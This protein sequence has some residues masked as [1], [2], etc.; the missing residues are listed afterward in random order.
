M[1]KKII[2]SFIDTV[3]ET[4]DKMQFID[5]DKIVGD[6]L[7]KNKIVGIWIDT[8]ERLPKNVEDVFIKGIHEDG[9]L[10][11]HLSWRCPD[12]KQRYFD[13]HSKATWSVGSAKNYTVTHWCYINDP[14]D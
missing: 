6:L 12:V 13:K 5:A 3:N 11:Y 7:D 9:T 8:K 1:D 2:Q 10:F 4:V 14:N